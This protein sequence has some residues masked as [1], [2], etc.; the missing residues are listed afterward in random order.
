MESPTMI[1]ALDAL[2]A[3][4]PPKRPYPPGT[5]SASRIIT[6]PA[7]GGGAPISAPG[8][9]GY[10]PPEDRRVRCED[11]V[12]ELDHDLDYRVHGLHHVR[13]DVIRACAKRLLLGFPSGPV[14]PAEERAWAYARAIVSTPDRTAEIGMYADGRD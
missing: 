13:A 11:L 8:H 7:W 3:D 1:E 4:V 6:K 2:A 9:V 14:R 10:L 5:V 12:Q